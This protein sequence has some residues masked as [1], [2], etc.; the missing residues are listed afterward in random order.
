MD[1][2]LHHDLAEF[3]TLTRPLLQADPVR[4]SLALTALALL[5]GM[6][7][8][9]AR[10]PVL[11]SVHRAGVLAGAAVRLP[12]YDLIV[13]GLPAECA[14]VAV[15][16]L[17][18]S[19]PGLPGTVGPR[20]EAEGFAHRWSACTGTSAHQ[21]MAQRVFALDQLTP[22][23]GVR[24]A[25]RRADASDLELLAQWREAFAGEATGGLRGHGTARQQA[26]G[27]LVAG[28]A[29]L[30]WEIGGHPVAWASATAPVAGMSRIGPVYTPPRYRGH[31]YGSA[32]TAAAAGWARQAGAKHV[33]L[34]T[35][36]ANP[37]SNAIYP[38]VGFRPMHDAVEIAF[39]RSPER[40]LARRT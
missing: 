5:P 20:G 15:E 24:G 12:P 8:V 16:V 3:T 9:T 32:V 34:F 18:P 19:H 10:P 7:D 6:P 11:L 26:S 28:T 40:G 13:S 29:A 35:D 25:P 31:G 1:A 27:S 4:H 2:R 37:V 23:R 21:R 39:T 22:P 38:R 36:L 30:L 17:A 14:A 33:V